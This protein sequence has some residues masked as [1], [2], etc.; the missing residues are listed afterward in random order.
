M[1]I[2]KIPNNSLTKEITEIIRLSHELE[3]DYSFEY[4]LPISEE[5][6]TTWETEHNIVIPN[7]VK[8]WLRFSNG[9]KI[10]NSLMDIYSL[11]KF[12]LNRK[13]MPEDLIIIGDVIGDGE[14]IA[15][16]KTTGKIIWVDHGTFDEYSDLKV[17][18]E[19]IIRMLDDD[20]GLSQSSQNLLMSFV[21]KSKKESND[22]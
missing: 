22:L 8:D 21:N 19:E 1:Y 5:E 7:S 3:N 13:G 11:S 12:D 15:F 2:P 6:I 20:C 17:V 9:S 4:T 10:R 18:L 14:F 16:S